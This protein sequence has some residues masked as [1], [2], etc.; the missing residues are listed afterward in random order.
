M[1]VLLVVGDEQLSAASTAFFLLFCF[2]LNL[3][4]LAK[5]CVKHTEGRPAVFWDGGGVVVVLLV[6]GDEQLFAA[7]TAGARFKDIFLS[8][9]PSHHHPLPI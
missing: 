4:L 1:V 5:K 3:R 6:V 8:T 7:S 2:Q 9:P